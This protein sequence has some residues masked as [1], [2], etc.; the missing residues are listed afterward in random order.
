VQQLLAEGYVG[1]TRVCSVTYLGDYRLGGAYNWRWDARRANGI[2]GDLGAHAIQFA[3]L[4]V[5]EIVRVS[6][7][8]RACI[9]RADAEGRPAPLASDT[10]VLALEFANGAHG[11]I[12]LSGGAISPTKEQ[13]IALYGDLGSLESEVTRPPVARARPG[14]EKLRPSSSGHSVPMT[15]RLGTDVF[16]PGR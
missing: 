1:Q 5:G 6:A 3:R 16:R 4:Y 7:D 14:A 12:Q 15:A 13:R 11:T 2:L 9:E 10:A 8:L